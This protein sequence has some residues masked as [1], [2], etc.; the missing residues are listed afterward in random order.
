MDNITGALQDQNSD[1]YLVQ[2]VDYDS[3]RTYKVD[4]RK[5]LRDGFSDH[6][7]TFAQNY[8]SSYIL[9]P[10][11]SPHGANKSGLVTLSDYGIS[12][13]IRRSLPIQTNIA[14]FMDLDRCYDLMRIP[15]EGGKDLVLINLHSEKGYFVKQ[16]I[17]CAQRTQPF[18]E[19]TVE[20]YAQHNRNNQ[21]A[22]LPRK[23]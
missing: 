7:Y 16:R 12:T 15:A 4:E 23:Q 18:A 3:T 2:E 5:I 14:K 21:D 19:R 13:S 17:K 22:E 11:N 1:L 10:F 8:N 6:S 20:Q 9:Y